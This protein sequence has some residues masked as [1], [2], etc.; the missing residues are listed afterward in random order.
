MKRL[1]AIFTFSVLAHAPAAS[2]SDPEACGDPDTPCILENDRSYH[3]RIPDDWDGTSE[4]PVML[5]FHGWKRQGTQPI[6]SE[7]VGE[8]TRRRGVLLVAPN[9][10]NRTWNFWSS[11]TADVYFAKNVLEDVAQKYPIDPNRV[12]VSGY[13]YGSAMAWRYACE[14]GDKVSAL[15]AVAGSLR[16]VDNCP[17]APD[18]VRHVHGLK[19]TVM[20]FPMGPNGDTRFPVEYWRNRFG[21]EAVTRNDG[22]APTDKLSFERVSWENCPGGTVHLDLHPRGHFIPRGWIARQ[23]DELLGREPSYP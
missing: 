22:W 1:A 4:L 18:E 2:R 20:R 3:L 9:G 23:L 12:Y 13:S 15:I 11:G 10:A 14:Y 19:D 7:R 6:N 8:A 17:Q 16:Q 21:C 5:F